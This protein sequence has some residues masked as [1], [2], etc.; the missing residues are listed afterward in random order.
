MKR[1]AT[2]T[3]SRSPLDPTAST[4]REILWANLATVAAGLIQG[5]GMVQLLWPF[6][7]QSV[8]I[9]LF[10]LRRMLAAPNVEWRY[11]LFFSVH[12]GGFHAMYLL[13]LVMLA[14]SADSAGMV[15]VTNTSTGEVM[16]LYAGR[17]SSLDIVI[18]LVLAV[19]FLIAHARSH[20]V[21]LAT[22]LAQQPSAGLLMMLPYL[23]ILPMHLTLLLGVILGG[24]GTVLLFGLLKTGADVGAHRLEHRMLARAR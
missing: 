13:F 21:Y 3:T 9:G 2:H 10:A 22:D 24:P 19:G 17:Q 12:Y 5:W 11:P 16:Q 20:R 8:I 18:E 6:W 14:G 4:A 7:A 1:S 15:P 23:R